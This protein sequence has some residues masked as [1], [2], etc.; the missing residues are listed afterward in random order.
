MRL[1]A[2]RWLVLC[3]LA[4]AAG[5][6]ASPLTAAS[7]R[8]TILGFTPKAGKPGAPVAITGRNLRGTKAVRF[9]RVSAQFTVVTPSLIV[10]K[11]P[12]GA[13]PGKISI[14]TKH[15]VATSKA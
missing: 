10:A 3:A 9:G 8:P 1:R 12:H 4:L 5:V 15:G 13:R 7:S 11:V 14:S 2:P 6:V